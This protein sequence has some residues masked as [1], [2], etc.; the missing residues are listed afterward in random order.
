MGIKSHNESGF[1]VSV[2]TP[3][4]EYHEFEFEYRSERL[5]AIDAW[6]IRNGFSQAMTDCIAGAKDQTV[7][8][9]KLATKYASFMRGE[10]PREG[11]IGRGFANEFEKEL[12]AVMVAILRKLGMKAADAADLADDYESAVRRI[13][14]SVKADADTVAAQLKAKAQRRV[15]DKDILPNVA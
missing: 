1:V 3:S 5:S 8:E 11:G 10:V 15:D 4:G 13:A 14:E 6:A 7:A 12:H 2:K 9:K